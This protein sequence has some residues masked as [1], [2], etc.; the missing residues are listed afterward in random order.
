MTQQPKKRKRLSRAESWLA[1]GGGGNE[2]AIEDKKAMTVTWDG[3]VDF[4]ESYE[5]YLRRKP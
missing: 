1:H 5:K 4:L 3:L 2:C